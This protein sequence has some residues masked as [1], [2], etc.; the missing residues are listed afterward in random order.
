M[1]PETYSIAQV[2]ERTGIGVETLRVWERRYQQPVPIRLPSG[3]RRYTEEQIRRLRRVAEAIA[4]G[5]RPSRVLSK[6]DVDLERLLNPT[7]H[8]V[9]RNRTVELVLELA[10]TYDESGIRE[11][12]AKERK[13]LG[14]ESFLNHCV[15][16]LV[17]TVGA[18]WEQGRFEIR[19]EH[20][21]SEI[22]GTLLRDLRQQIALPADAP[23]VVLTTFPGETHVIGIHIAALTLTQAGMRPHVLGAQSPVEEIVK[24][25][26]ET[27]S[28]AVGVSV[29]LA[30]CG[31]DSEKKL[32]AVRRSL[33]DHVA[34]LAGGQGARRLRRGVRGVQYVTNTTSI[35]QWVSERLGDKR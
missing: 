34:V 19:H 26:V 33:P 5:H 1:K 3:H 8:T 11:A 13:A 15:V 17:E 20:F 35:E 10:E 28:I 21:I 4:R 32:S 29:S 9:T 23:G 14:D 12:L 22:L 27:Q 16:P 18:R 7:D 25:V 24:A 6:S 31:V 30:T 2:A